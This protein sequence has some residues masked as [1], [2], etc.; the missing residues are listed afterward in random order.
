[1]FGQ[2]RLFF[3]KKAKDINRQSFG[4]QITIEGTSFHI[5]IEGLATEFAILPSCLFGSLCFRDWG[6]LDVPRSQR[7]PREHQLNTIGT[8]LPGVHPIVPWLFGGVVR[9]A[10]NQMVFNGKIPWFLYYWGTILWPLDNDFWLTGTL[11]MMS[12]CPTVGCGFYFFELQFL[13]ESSLLLH[14][15]VF[16]LFFG[17]YT[18]RIIPAGKVVRNSYLEAI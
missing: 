18:W 3:Q 6:Q 2:A 17:W 5:T 14:C 11:V 16:F 8:L 9:K 10:I 13:I 7:T 4:P 15:F 1:M 12:W